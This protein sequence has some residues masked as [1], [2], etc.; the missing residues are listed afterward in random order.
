[1]DRVRASVEAVREGR[2]PPED[3]YQGA[4]IAELAAEP[5]DPVPRMLHEIERS[6]KRFGIHFD[7]WA[8]QS[9]LEENLDEILAGLP[10]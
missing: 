4:Y 9:V 1:M 5:G 8:K 6:L 3:G 2:E 7:S 10:T